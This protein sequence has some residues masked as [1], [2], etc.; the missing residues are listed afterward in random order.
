MCGII[1]LLEKIGLFITKKGIFKM[2]YVVY[3]ASGFL[4][5]D[6][7]IYS[8]SSK[9][10]VEIKELLKP[11]QIIFND[12]ATIVY[13]EDGTKTVVKCSENEAFVPE[14]GLAMAYMRKIYPERGEFLSFVEKAYYQEDKVQKEIKQLVDEVK[15]DVAEKISDSVE[16]EESFDGGGIA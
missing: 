12:P 10:K 8:A 14:F 9:T 3:K 1:F 13:W 11:R 6:G 7:S 15:N 2:D 4:N 16:V 5:T